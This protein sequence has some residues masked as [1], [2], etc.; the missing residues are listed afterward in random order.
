MVR[1]LLARRLWARPACSPLES[2]GLRAPTRTPLA[3]PLRTETRGANP[4]HTGTMHSTAGRL[5]PV[6]VSERVLSRAV[7]LSLGATLSSRS[8]AQ[9]GEPP[10]GARGFRR[11]CRHDKSTSQRARLN[12][13]QRRAGEKRRRRGRSSRV[14]RLPVQIWQCL[15]WRTGAGRLSETSCGGSMSQPGPPSPETAASKLLAPSR[16]A[17]SFSSFLPQQPTTPPKHS[18][19]DAFL[20]RS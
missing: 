6:V 15:G 3:F 19:K 16:R 18:H 7:S 4:H 2:I 1:T 10:Q 9:R 8:W 20:A 13:F 11:D 14:K 5:C 17:L 12:T